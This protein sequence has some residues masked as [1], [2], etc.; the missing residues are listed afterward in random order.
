MNSWNQQAKDLLETDL[1]LTTITR[2]ENVYFQGFTLAK[3][4]YGYNIGGGSFAPPVRLREG[5]TMV[6]VRI[7]GVDFYFRVER[8]EQPEAGEELSQMG[9]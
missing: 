2:L 5:H 8:P 9:R 3:H 6:V 7:K 1:I 4:Q